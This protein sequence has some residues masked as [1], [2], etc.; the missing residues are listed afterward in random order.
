M[1]MQGNY[2]DHPTLGLTRVPDT[3]M[4]NRYEYVY[5]PDLG[6]LK[7]LKKVVKKVTKPIVR[8]IE[9]LGKKTGI[10]KLIP[11]ELKGGVEKP[12]AL[13][14]AGYGL[15]TLGAKGL[16]TGSAAKAGAAKAGGVAAKVGSGALTAVKTVAPVLATG[17]L[18]AAK[19]AGQVGTAVLEQAPQLMAAQ[20]ALQQ[21]RAQAEINQI[22][23][24]AQLQALA[25][26]QEHELAMQQIALQRAQSSLPPQA[27]VYPGA[28]GP[29]SMNFSMPGQPAAK[30]GGMDNQTMMLIGAGVIAV[31][32]IAGR[33]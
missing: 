14:A 25:A 16:L 31:A 23:T 28:S 4:L 5:D 33:K 27:I 24:Q 11:K 21:Q 26:Q 17:A 2:Y 10:S 32:L 19:T 1:K 6:F 9:K 3:V 29:P 30:A 18:T 12:L 13:A 7:K 8:P 15:Y 22:E 20:Q